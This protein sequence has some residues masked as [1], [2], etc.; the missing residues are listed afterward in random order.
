MHMTEKLTLMAC[1]KAE[2]ASLKISSKVSI[3]AAGARCA[4]GTNKARARNLHE[5][6]LEM[7]QQQQTKS[8]MQYL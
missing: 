2:G 4:N 3:E 7:S 8:S 5:M 1:G 6:K